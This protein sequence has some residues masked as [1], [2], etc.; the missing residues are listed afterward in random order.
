ML[1][2]EIFEACVLVDG[3][4]LPE[5][6]VTTDER[7][8][9]ATC[10]IPSEQGKVSEI[11]KLFRGDIIFISYSMGA[12][13][14]FSVKFRNTKP[15]PKQLNGRLSTDGNR[16]FSKRME[17]STCKAT[18][19]SKASVNATTYREM[20][21]S[22]IELTGRK[23]FDLLALIISINTP[24]SDDDAY[25]DTA[26]V[27]DLGDI[28]LEILEVRRYPGKDIHPHTIN[29]SDGKIHERTKKAM[30]HHIG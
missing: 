25:L 18:M 23:L 14:A 20:V 30:G 16:I 26:N 24:N 15:Y 2:F 13:Q 10:W 28:T 29:V 1:K 27:K 21:F 7:S 8:K 19:V 22:S 11:S 12:L 5:Y 17:N 9:T 4:E 3:V 6:N